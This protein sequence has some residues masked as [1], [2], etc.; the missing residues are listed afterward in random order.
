MHT[1]SSVLSLFLIL[2]SHS[3]WAN[4]LCNLK[5]GAVAQCHELEDV[6]YI[7]TYDLESLRATVTERILQP[8]YF[9]NLTSLRHLDLSG[10]NLEQIKP[11]S[12]RKLINLRSLNLA[13]NRIGYL[14][15]GS[16]NGLNH[17]HSLNLRRNNLRQL[18][19]TLA[20]LKVLRH[21]DIQG[22]PL[23]C[24]CATLRVRD[25]I[26]KR[27]VKLSKK[28]LC[29]G[30]SSM[31]GTSLFKPDATSICNF[32]EQDGEMQRDQSYE[33]SEDEHGSG[34][35]PEELGKEEE[36]KDCVKIETPF[37]EALEISTTWTTKPAQLD[38]DESE[39]PPEVTTAV[40][41]VVSSTPVVDSI[42]RTL[43]KDQEI[44]F[45]SDEKKDQTSTIVTTERK[46]V[47]KDALFY[48]V[49][50]SGDEDEGSGEGSGAGI[51]FG[52]WK[53]VGKVE[54]TSEKEEESTSL[55]D[56][57]ISSL[58]N[59]FWS[60]TETPEMKK[61]L[62][63]EGEQF[64]DASPTEK[65]DEKPVVSK[66]IDLN[67]AS[68]STTE[69]AAEGTAVASTNGI[70]L[71]DSDLHDPSKMGEVKIGEDDVNDGLAEVS[72]AKQSKKGMGSYVVLAAL[73]AILATLI[74]FAAYKGN[75]CKKKRK[76]GDVENGT[77][78]KDM[79][80][81]LLD[82]ENV[83]QPKISSNGNVENIPLVEDAIDHDERKTSHDCQNQSTTNTP[84]S[85]NGTADRVEPVKPP[86]RSVSSQDDLRDSE[87]T[88]RDV[89]SVKDNSLSARTS[90]IDPSVN[91]GPMAQ[92]S[93]V[94]GPPLS[95]GAQRVKITL[96]ENPDSVPRT[97]I[98]ITRTMAGE[99][100]VKTP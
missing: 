39:A 88:G 8:D 91:N 16:M 9:S 71:V 79:Q 41:E 29:A 21:L 55:G 42:E 30:P 47:Y 83:T 25:L 14:D 82:T 76:R 48:P 11:G 38:I 70:E 45:D 75:F 85:Q 2:L 72:P 97:P 98:L 73:L 4:G 65:A 81:A 33:G 63:L 23:E 57:I 89:S 18:P 90:P 56:R 74:G 95:P 64:F 50:G 15:L 27:G 10:G 62:D 87:T 20:H 58:F 84:K 60:T 32:E 94:N 6:K 69:M 53:K 43:D 100:L 12:L 92:L 26:L 35:V 7:E 49:E 77:E 59:M 17:L 99:N 19:P 36:C 93:E 78:L 66:N 13:E 37:Q 31:K 46:K 24:N 34:D 80:K 61:D 68:L 86:R 3:D 44:F 51:L 96:Q 67:E 22:N 5:N 52:E 1:A 40:E 54:D 28:I